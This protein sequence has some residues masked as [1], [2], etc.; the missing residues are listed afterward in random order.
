LGEEIH[1]PASTS[2]LAALVAELQRKGILTDEETRA[3]YEQALLL[4]ENSPGDAGEGWR[5]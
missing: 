2:I 4:L 1:A 5:S 3:V